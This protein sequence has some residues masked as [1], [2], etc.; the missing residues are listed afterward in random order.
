MLSGA[1][2]LTAAISRLAEFPWYVSDD[3]VTPLEGHHT[4]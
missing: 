1:R 3:L 2:E 4:H